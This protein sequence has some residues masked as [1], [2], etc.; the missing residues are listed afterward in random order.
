MGD[1]GVIFPF[2]DFDDLVDFTDLRD[3]MDC[4]RWDGCVVG[5]EDDL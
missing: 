3:E 1:V 4:L 5:V 2:D